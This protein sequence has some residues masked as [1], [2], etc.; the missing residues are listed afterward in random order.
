M[1]GVYIHCMK[2]TIY[3]D[4]ANDDDDDD[5]DDA[6]RA[7]MIVSPTLLTW[8]HVGLPGPLMRRV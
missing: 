1:R 6:V 5:D 4:A 8:L 2:M 7:C 3:I